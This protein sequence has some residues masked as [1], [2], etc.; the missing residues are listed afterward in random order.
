MKVSLLHY[1]HKRFINK[2]EDYI[3]DHLDSA[4]TLDDIAKSIG[5]SKFYF[6]RLFKDQCEET[7]NQYIVRIKME[8]S[9]IFLLVHKDI[10]IAKIAQGYGYNDSSSYIRAFKRVHGITPDEYRKARIDNT[11]I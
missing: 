5:V 1:E 3:N 7:L 9:A 11:S 4:I 6:H 10:T 2:A 8:R